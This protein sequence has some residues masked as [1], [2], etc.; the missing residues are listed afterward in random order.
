MLLLTVILAKRR[1]AREEG[2]AH[3]CAATLESR[4][5]PGRLNTALLSPAQAVIFQNSSI[6][7]FLSL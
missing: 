5:H 6:L 2:S 3:V 1:S 4:T 7:A